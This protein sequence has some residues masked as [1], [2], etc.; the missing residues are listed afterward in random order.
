M[1]YI[2]HTIKAWEFNQLRSQPAKMAS[3]V[4]FRREPE[5]YDEIWSKIL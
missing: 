2:T 4:Q 5:I 3:G 1:K